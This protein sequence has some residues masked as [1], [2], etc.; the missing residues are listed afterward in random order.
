[1]NL[2]REFALYMIRIMRLINPNVKTLKFYFF[3]NILK[4]RNEMGITNP[5]SHRSL[6]LLTWAPYSTL[7]LRHTSTLLW[8]SALNLIFVK[9]L[10]TP[11]LPHASAAKQICSAQPAQAL[12]GHKYTHLLAAW[13]LLVSC[14]MPFFLQ[15]IHALLPKL[16]LPPP[17]FLAMLHPS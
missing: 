15:F 7:H 6:P 8:P 9:I 10:E 4:N 1:M 14:G 16:Q 2:K 12:I 17:H 3:Y 5:C 11:L 13:P